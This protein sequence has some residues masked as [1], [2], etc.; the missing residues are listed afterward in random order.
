[1]DREHSAAPTAKS[2]TFWGRL[3]FL[4]GLGAVVGIGLWTAHLQRQAYQIE[5]Q[6]GLLRQVVS[7]AGSVDPYLGQ[8]LTF[9]SV[10][11][12]S[13]AFEVIRERLL[14]ASQGV[15]CRGIYTLALREGQ[16][17]FGPETYREDDPMASPPG[18]R[19]EQPPEGLLEVFRQ[20]Q[21]R[22]IGPY[23]DGYRTFV[24]AFAPVVL[25]EN[26]QVVLVVGMDL[27]AEDWQRML[28][29]WSAK[30]WLTTGLA[31]LGVLGSTATVQWI[32]RRKLQGPMRIRTWIFWPMALA[33][34]FCFLYWLVW[35]RSL[36]K[37]TDGGT[38]HRL[39]MQTHMEWEEIVRTKAKVLQALA[40]DLSEN[41]DLWLTWRRRD[42]EG[43]QRLS[44]AL[45]ERLR[46]AFH[47]SHLYFV[48]PEGVCF[49]R[50]HR[51]ED[52]GDPI[53]MGALRTA[54]RTGEP[55]YGVDVG[56]VGDF[57]L[58]Y[59]WPWRYGGK[60]DGYL[61]LGIHLKDLA[62][63]IQ[64]NLNAQ[65]ILAFDKTYL[66][67]ERFEHGRQMFGYHGQ[68]ETYPH[69]VIAY[70]GLPEL[71]GE[72]H[73]RFQSGR[74]FG[75]EEVF[76]V[77]SG[78]Q[79]WEVG[80][81]VLRNGM[82][83]K[84]GYLLV[85]NDVTARVDLARK[86]LWLSASL[87]VVFGCGLL[88]FLATV[89]RLAEGQ[90]RKAFSDLSQQRQWFAA[91]LHSIGDGVISTDPQGCVV[92]MNPAAERMT[93]WTTAEAL[94]KPI[95][96]VFRIVQASTGQEAPNPVHQA[97]QTGQVV[98]L[99]NDTTLIGRDGS[100]RQ[101]ADTC[102]PIREQTGQVLG[103]VLVFHDVSK[104]YHLKHTLRERLKELGCL[105]RIRDLLDGRW[106]EESLCRQAAAR[107]AE[108]MQWPELAQVYVEL[109]GRWYPADPQAPADVPPQL[110]ENPTD[111]LQAAIQ[112]DQ[113]KCGRILVF[114]KEPRGFLLPYEQ[115]LV[116]G[117]ARFLGDYLE[118]QQ[119]QEALQTERSK[120]EA[121]FEASPVGL[122]VFDGQGN[123]LQLNQV[124]AD[125]F[126]L[127]PHQALRS[128]PGNAFGCVHAR[129][130][131]KGCGSSEHCPQCAVRQT[132]LRA[133]LSHQPQELEE[134]RLE[135]EKQGQIRPVWVYWR[136]QPIQLAGQWYAVAA[137][138]DITAR[139]QAEQELQHTLELALRHQA[140][141][142]ALL[143]AA[144]AVLHHRQFQ[145]AAQRICTICKERVGATAAYIAL[146]NQNG[147]QTEIAY[148]DTGPYPCTIQNPLPMP[149]RGIR[150][151][152]YESR[153]P[154]WENQFAE[155]PWAELLPPG[156]IRLHNVMIV[157][158]MVEGK[159][160]GLMALGNKPGDFTLEDARI[161]SALA[162]MAAIAL[163]NSQNLDSLVRQQQELQRYA[164]ALETTNRV[165]KE[166]VHLA[167]SAARAK[168][169]FLA[170]M[171]HE[172]R[173]PMTAILGYTELL[174]SEVS[175]SPRKEYLQT[176]LRNGQ[177][178]LQLLD[179]IL[180]LSKIEAGKLK[181]HRTCCNPRQIA[182]EVQE[183]LQVRAEEKGIQLT[184]QCSPNLPEQ[185]WSDPVRLRQILVNLV[186]NAVKFTEVGSV[187]M[188]VHAIGEP[189]SL[190]WDVIDTGIG[191]TPEQAARIFQP[192]SQGDSSVTRKYGGTGL[193]LAI[194]RRL[195]EL[196]GGE[197]CLVRTA[198]GVGS[199]FRLTLPIDQDAPQPA[200]S[201]QTDSLP[202]TLPLA[203]EPTENRVAC[204]EQKADLA[205][206][207]S[208]ELPATLLSVGRMAEGSAQVLAGC[209]VLLAEDAVENQR[210]LALILRKAGAEV[211]VVEHGQAAVQA[212][213]QAHQ[214]GQPFDL[215]LMDMQMPVMDGYSAVQQLRA[216]GYPGPIIALTAHAMSED[217]QKC[218]QAGCNDYMSKP[219]PQAKLLQMVAQYAPGQNPTPPKGFLSPE[220]LT[221]PQKLPQP[222]GLPPSEGRSLPNGF[223]S[224]EGPTPSEELTPQEE[225]TLPESPT[226]PERPIPPQKLP[227]PEGPTLPEGTLLPDGDL[228]ATLPAGKGPRSETHP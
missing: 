200:P 75:V 126:G 163:W 217:R 70:Q 145:E 167:E 61:C 220:G 211:T 114:Y 20:K 15:V 214:E 9:S 38:T 7:I 104:E 98:E 108:G 109:A 226:P 203:S 52:Y 152:A 60:Q 210:L 18:T 224:P 77:E 37:E 5:L 74:P 11:K 99:S 39:I 68:W 88:I 17:R 199:H 196:L 16:L 179:D 173:T 67:Q 46:E 31:L 97:L 136:I 204:A 155:S 208:E 144:K 129:Q 154:V 132:L 69:V 130:S 143:E 156:H 216:E 79:I 94:G 122:L 221:P 222:E 150:K 54:M 12:G 127:Q 137:F 151:L 24:S 172:I 139:K 180:D 190:Q 105:H 218:L 92:D 6:E 25:P 194:S 62:E 160:L 115:Q 81:I 135:L 213:L 19:Y 171:S 128:Q 189:A 8:K 66:T 42:R 197:L 112:V 53:Q 183:L 141:T 178:L 161:A 168:S 22:V 59:V 110:P 188:V 34:V 32:R 103:A 175:E 158:L 76:R 40:Q 45:F 93:G 120:L 169:E 131:A 58:R 153:V 166:F 193:G 56:K 86:G 223:P 147:E 140:E 43:L 107:L 201:D 142:A 206:T 4:V 35:K 26:E 72:I 78:P 14:E 182:T 82:G 148:M 191:M 30:T 174:L 50:C 28:R 186:G 111:L 184:L 198:P 117:V 13:P 91:T 134:A 95:Q 138:Q 49:F 192:F 102:A 3:L 2:S 83:Q 29:A 181:I 47:V 51:P 21:P 119:A 65:I 170:N 33:V 80:G 55:A 118:H 177:Y 207:P 209:R 165:L 100:Q 27:L 64:R 202:E 84:V 225:L 162:D 123:I 159:V 121:I 124:A 73:R 96:E 185:I 157:P 23:T 113:E 228:P 212:A 71:P 219:I 116:E 89:T 227:Q 146:V 195:A 44:G 125:Y 63:A 41:F 101:I 87:G 106:E 1:M 57:T 85:L 36:W 149:L 205:P 133:L 187:Q 10:D 215:I 176:I 164:E 48:T 90:L